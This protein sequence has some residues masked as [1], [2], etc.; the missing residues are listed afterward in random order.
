MGE[1]RNKIQVDV[2]VDEE[3]RAQI[4]LGKLN[5][6][7]NSFSTTDA[8]QASAGFDALSASA[9]KFADDLVKAG[10]APARALQEAQKEE[11]ALKQKIEESTKAA[12]AAGIT[13]TRSYAEARKEIEATG[14]SAQRLHNE[15]LAA[16]RAAFEARARGAVPVSAD[17]AAL[18]AAER[19]FAARPSFEQF[20]AGSAFEN[21]SARAAA[22][23]TAREAAISQQRK[24]NEELA[25]SNDLSTTLT[26]NIRGVGNPMSA[27]TSAVIGGSLLTAAV[28]DVTS[29]GAAWIQTAKDAQASERL[30]SVAAMDYSVS[31][32]EA[33]KAA[34]ELAEANSRSLSSSQAAAIQAA[35]IGLASAARRPQDA[36]QAG[37][38]AVDLA[39]QRGLSADQLPALLRQIEAGS[40]GALRSLTG[41]EDATAIER[42]AD[43]H[44]LLAEKLTEAEKAAARLD[45]VTRRGA[46][47]RG[48]AQSQARTFTSEMERVF[49]SLSV[50]YERPVT[51]IF[52]FG[53]NEM[54]EGVKRARQA[55]AEWRGEVPPALDEATRAVLLFDDASQNAFSAQGISKLFADFGKTSDAQ[56]AAQT[57]K[58]FRLELEAATDTEDLTARGAALSQL[59]EGL[60]Q[61][62]SQ[63]AG[64]P[65]LLEEVDEI[66]RRIERAGAQT[67][68]EVAKKADEELKKL[69]NLRDEA[70]ALIHEISA[71]G[72]GDNPFVKLLVDADRTAESLQKRFKDL[73]SDV[74]RLLTQLEGKQFFKQLD[75]LRLSTQLTAFDLRQE[76]RR[77]REGPE[78]T[79]SPEEENA[80]F[81]AFVGA[82]SRGDIFASAS[83]PFATQTTSARRLQER[84]RE[85][86]RIASTARDAQVGSE[87]RDRSL[88]EAA[89][90][91]RPEDLTREIREQAARA[92]ERESSRVLQREE[93]SIQERKDRA[94]VMSKLNKLMTDKGL[95]IDGPPTTVNVNFNDSTSPGGASASP[96]ILGSTPRAQPTFNSDAQRSMQG[97]RTGNGQ[98]GF[99]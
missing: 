28:R 31:L 72:A 33:T 61:V 49:N 19:A 73:G 46:I 60:A 94:A 99:E 70:A 57:I 37:R 87:F 63:V 85:I 95:K 30:L 9:R 45:A 24:L 27:L 51:G 47:F 69:K 50:I 34:K 89:R 17:P 15:S 75:T 13:I 21:F 77:V 91:A 81:Q 67:A 42:Y 93:Q 6:G 97:L 55:W 29:L 43:A 90:G 16:Q 53:W 66:G 32:S 22:Q 48:E 14:K 36:P 86:D 26:T 59:K 52:V 25:K 54:T 71:R 80:R 78:R 65:A 74:V 18:A 2:L 10:V 1:A 40:P 20:T 98:F 5:Q 84:L 92:L 23:N 68:R 82:I 38:A 96:G 56:A 4:Q 58:N 3:G 76:A 41:T 64:F 35:A 88:I 11:A 12:E 44:G 7:L 79:L 62:R 83:S 8:P 39:A